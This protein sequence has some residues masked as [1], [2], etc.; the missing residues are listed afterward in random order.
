M[1]S[2]IQAL[3]SNPLQLNKKRDHFVEGSKKNI[4][5]DLI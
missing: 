5:V 2:S 3:S 4:F 1:E